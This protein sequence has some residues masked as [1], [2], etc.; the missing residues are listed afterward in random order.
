[1]RKIIFQFTPQNNLFKYIIN[2]SF[3]FFYGVFFVR[4]GEKKG[5]VFS[6]N[7]KKDFSMK[8]FLRLG[9]TL[10]SFTHSNNKILNR[11]ALEMQ[12]L[13]ILKGVL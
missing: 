4:N 11:K 5:G 8:R 9:R 3:R 7:T 2:L 13:F 1:M 12:D 10:P 6:C